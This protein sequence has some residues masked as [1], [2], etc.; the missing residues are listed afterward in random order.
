MSSDFPS[1]DPNNW[2]WF[3]VDRKQFWS[4]KEEAFVEKASYYTQVETAEELDEVLR[5]FGLRSPVVTPEAVWREAES[6]RFNLV[7]AGSL[8]HYLQITSNA[9][10]EAIYLLNLKNDREWTEAEAIRAGQLNGFSLVLSA[11]D[12]IAA[13]LA[14]ELPEN[15]RDD[16][17]WPNF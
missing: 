17:Y 14:V 5:R 10:M 12:D 6:R 11:I 8:P 3:V 13:N 9:H 1:F 2:F 7:G 15:F 16:K 4:S